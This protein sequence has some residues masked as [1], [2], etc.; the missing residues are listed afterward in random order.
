MPRFKLNDITGKLRQQA[1]AQIGTVSARL[2]HPKPEQDAGVPPLGENQDEEGGTGRFKVR[3]TR[4]AA[5]LLDKDNLYGSIKWVCD[6]LRYEGLI[7]EDD[8]QA[9][10]LEVFQEI[11]P[12]AERGTH[13]LITPL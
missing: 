1:E 12:K 5:R 9:I 10:E 2:H 7:P 3:I 11:V 13:I 4:R 8:P 6:G